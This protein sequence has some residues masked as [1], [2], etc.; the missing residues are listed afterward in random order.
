M[1]LIWGLTCPLGS[2]PQLGIDGRIFIDLIYS[3]VYQWYSFDG[4]QSA[5][6]H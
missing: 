5:H 3:K 4:R 6:Q 2:I 1:V